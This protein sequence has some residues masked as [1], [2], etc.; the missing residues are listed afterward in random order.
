MKWPHSNITQ[1]NRQQSTDLRRVSRSSGRPTFHKSRA[2]VDGYGH[3]RQGTP[4]PEVLTTVPRPTLTPNRRR[5]AL[6][7]G[8]VQ[9]ERSETEPPL[10]HTTGLEPEQRNG[11]IEK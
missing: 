3:Q 6:E 11:K 1:N 9:T 8:S 4:D 2:Q 7:A 10:P 5:Q